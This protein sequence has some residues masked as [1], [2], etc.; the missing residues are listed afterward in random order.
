MSALLRI[1]GIYSHR[2]L[3]GHGYSVL[4]GYLWRVT[5]RGAGAFLCARAA[6][7]LWRDRWG[8]HKIRALIRRSAPEVDTCLVGSDESD[9][10]RLGSGEVEPCSEG[11]D[12][13]DPGTTGRARRSSA[14]EGL[15]LSD[16]GALGR[17]ETEWDV[18]YLYWVGGNRNYRRWAWAFMTVALRGIRRSL[19]SP[20]AHTYLSVKLH[21]YK[22]KMYL[23]SHAHNLR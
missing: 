19:I 17:T 7:Y 3:C 13:P 10:L 9:P 8:A 18:L 14:I 6:V 1:R 21:L 16:P 11:S 15:G 5:S 22:V 23:S 2:S 4:L 12:A 20:H